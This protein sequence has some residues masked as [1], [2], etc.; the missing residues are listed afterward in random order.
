MI[1]MA[2]L[3][4]NGVI[5][6]FILLISIFRFYRVRIEVAYINQRKVLCAICK[7]N[8]HLMF[9]GALFDDLIGYECVEPYY[10]TIWRFWDFGCS[11]IVPKD[12]WDVIKDYIE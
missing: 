11:R 12:V 7:Y 3:L 5:I 1:S 6:P 2:S 4:I 10:E 9:E 8:Y